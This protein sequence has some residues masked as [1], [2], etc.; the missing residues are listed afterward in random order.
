MIA[1]PRVALWLHERSLSCDE[2]EAVIGDVIEEFNLRAAVNVA[3][4]RRWIWAEAC[5]SAPHNLG[6]RL[7]DQRGATDTVP[8]NGARMLNGF[9]TDLRFATRLL[10]R[11]PFV[12]FV[13]LVSLAAG[14]GLNILLLA[15]ADAALV[16][17]LPLHDP[18]RLVLLLLQRE[19]GFMHNF[20]YPDYEE[21]RR[22]ATVVDSL[23]AYS[24]VETSMA[25]SDG[26]TSVEGEVVSGNFFVALGVPLRTGR[27]LSD[28]D[29]AAGAP[30]AV[31]V[32]EA[33]WRDR[34]GGA[35]LS[36]QTVVLN[37]QPFTV[38]G[39]AGARFSGMQVGRNA[40]FWVALAH[41]PGL[42]GGDLLGRPTTS[43]LTV[44]ARLRDEATAE[45]AR[46][47][48]DAILRRIRESSGRPVE[49]VVLQPGA[50]GDSLLSGELASP[51]ALLLAAG[52]LVLLVACLNV[53]NLQLSRT[54][55]RRRELAVRSAL[56]A[57]RAQLVR[58][59]L[60]DGG[61]MAGA[62]GLAAVWLAVLLKD[63]AASLIA[64]YGRPVALSIPFDGRVVGM[65]AL[66]SGAAALV[67]G[68][69]SSWQM[70][71]RHSANLADGR[72][73]TGRRRPAQRALV[74]AQVALSMALLVGASLLVRTLDRLRHADLGFD[75]RGIA[76]LQVSPEM[77]RLARVAA[78]TYFDEAV[79]AVEALPGVQSAGVAHV[80]PLDFGGSRTTIGIA[81]YTP[82]PDEDMELNFVRVSPGYFRTLG[83]SA[84][85]GRT[86][87]ERDRDGQPERIIVNETMARR[88]WPDGK[89]TGRFVRFDSRAP[90]NVEVIG[91]VPDAHYRM[92][93]E[94]STPTF[95]VPLAQWPSAAGV[96]H[97]R[98]TEPSS[99]LA[100]LRR[101]VAAVNPAVPVIRAHTLPDQVERN[102]A[103]ERLAMTIGLTLAL[104]ALLLATAG[105]YATMAF[106]VGRRTREIGVRLALGARTTEVRSLV[107][108][109]GLALALA[110]VA[111]GLAF[112]I[113]V[114]RALRHQLYGVGALDVPSLIGAAVVLA[115]AAL[116][117]SW[118]PARRAARVDPVIALRDC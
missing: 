47:E 117:A 72:G 32:S 49:P 41:S 19:S 48:L 62:A 92:V 30:P 106:N 80:M 86:F 11:Q 46:Q 109:E 84:R 36:G 24:A 108:R 10:K 68:V 34:F 29:D 104:V 81:G 83:L 116:L 64:L 15:L 75:P 55:A 45:S 96:L 114:G 67:V 97:V 35:A 90:F 51:M 27:A 111:C 60:I 105:L 44:V 66:L 77:G 65:A 18:G 63:Q 113:W 102:I 22:R 28:A 3:S 61:L 56:G 39:V 25:G 70:L 2:R 40:D 53:V 57:R 1:P 37:G 7:R 74:V 59:A 99:R 110:G 20:S 76:V 115:A 23:V 91:V 100:E 88:F 42:A 103:D 107:L 93:R 101:V 78:S 95:Y 69:L 54:E 31:V 17:P 73:E 26:A 82:A 14:L 9:V 71:R 12:S 112:S 43:W 89:A 94:L 21:L 79:A 38:V 33:L 6:R 13:A 50:R 85:E 118:L 98:V 87:D 16:R 8:Q 52:A 4:A 5:R 58:L